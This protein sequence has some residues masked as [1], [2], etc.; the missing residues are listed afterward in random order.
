MTPTALVTGGASGI[1]AATVERF[2]ARGYDVR[3]VDRAAGHDVRDP[4]TARDAVAACPRLDA[5]VC[6]AGIGEGT[7]DDILAVNLTGAHHFIDAAAPRF[8]EQRS[9]RVVLVSST[10]ALR[11]RPRL[12]AYAASKAGLI[13]LVRGAA[14]DLGPHGVTVNA[15]AP[16]L[17][18]TPMTAAI[19]DDIKQRLR[20]ETCLGR[21]GTPGD[22]AAVIL[23]L[24]SEDA[25]HVTGEVIR[26]DGGQLA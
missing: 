9:G 26:V 18:D 19:P 21:T 10:Q 15:V 12:Q 22:V 17:I 16:G 13:G 3:V 5:L 6:C 23:F 24:C 25:R 1:G 14:R 20:D 11:A 2:R 8:R 4:K 7:W